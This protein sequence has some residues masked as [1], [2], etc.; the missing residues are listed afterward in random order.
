MNEIITK[1]ILLPTVSGKNM[2]QLL[3]TFIVLLALHGSPVSAEP[4]LPSP[5]RKAVKSKTPPPRIIPRKASS[6]KGLKPKIANTK[7]TQKTSTPAIQKPLP[8]SNFDTLYIPLA[9]VGMIDTYRRSSLPQSSWGDEQEVIVG[10]WG[11]SYTAFFRFDI[12]GLPTKEAGDIIELQLY[13]MSRGENQKPTAFDVYQADSLV[14]DTING[15]QEFKVDPSS[16]QTIDTPSY[17]QW[18]SIDI[19]EYVEQWRTTEQN[20]GIAITPALT[21]N[22]FNF[23][24]SSESQKYPN[25]RPRIRIRKIP[26]D[27]TLS[28]SH[29]TST[30]GFSSVMNDNK[31]FGEYVSEVADQNITIGFNVDAFIPI[32]RAAGYVNYINKNTKK[33]CSSLLHLIST[34]DDGSF[35]FRQSIRPSETACSLSPNVTLVNAGVVDQDYGIQK[36][37]VTW[38]DRSS[39]KILAS[40]LFEQMGD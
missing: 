20:K 11:D 14:T 18:V 13:N 29:V 27:S 15:Y 23:F 21:N 3:V 9:D 31:F 12:E 39:G 38:T 33:T 19:T 8:P 25:F 7:L 32:L 37:S 2:L 28:Q 24:V 6:G 35:F 10:G 17:G 22:N 4:V 16:K 26:S 5:P 40:G 1:K 30:D 36:M 34:E